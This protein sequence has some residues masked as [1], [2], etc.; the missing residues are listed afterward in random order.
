M[1]G[2]ENPGHGELPQARNHAC[3][4][5][6]PLRRHQGHLVANADAQ[7][8]RQLYPQHDIEFARL[9]IIETALLDLAGHIRHLRLLSR[10]DTAYRHAAQH[11]VA[12][13][14]GL[15]IDIGRSA[16][17]FL[18]LERLFGD[19]FPVRH[20]AGRIEHLDMRQH[21]QHAV[22]HVF[23]EAVHHRQHHDQ[24]SHAQGDAGHR[25]QRDEGNKAVAATALTRTRIANAD[26]PLKR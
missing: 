20:G 23:L 17:H 2:L 9:E 14:H 21:R 24:R 8:M 18:V 13:Q 22:A 12:H 10:Q 25:Y 5:H 6:L 4:C 19:L 15:C 16:D 26:Q 11:A 7:G 1:A 3:R